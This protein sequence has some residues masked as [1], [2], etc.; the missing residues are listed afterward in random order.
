[1]PSYF[2]M[3]EGQKLTSTK[4]NFGYTQQS[5]PHCLTLRLHPQM[6]EGPG[7]QSEWLWCVIGSSGGLWKNGR[8]LAVSKGVVHQHH[9][10]MWAQRPCQLF[11][12]PESQHLIKCQVILSIYLNTGGQCSDCWPHF[13]LSHLQ[14]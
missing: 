8:S 10:G 3:L 1:M 11:K 9:T 7:G 12:K 13:S 2:H 5:L 14:L 4:D 6:P